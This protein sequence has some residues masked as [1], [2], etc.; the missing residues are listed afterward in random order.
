MAATYLRIDAIEQV[1]RSPGVIT[2][3]IGRAGYL[4]AY[5]LAENNLNASRGTNV[6]LLDSA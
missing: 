4:V 5:A 6:D 1:L 3:D 2:G